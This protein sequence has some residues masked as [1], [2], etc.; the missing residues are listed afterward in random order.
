MAVSKIALLSNLD[1]IYFLG[2][3]SCLELNNKKN[4][5]L[6]HWISL[7]Y[8]G[9]TDF[10]RMLKNSRN[11]LNPSFFF[12]IVATILMPLFIFAII[13]VDKKALRDKLDDL[14]PLNLNEEN[15]MPEQQDVAV[16]KHRHV[17]KKRFEWKSGSFSRFQVKG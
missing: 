1:T 12:Q 13:F 4:I 6:R 14:D 8:S 9:L 17:K 11:F 2:N 16:S 7:K 3:C 15:C 10:C 5:P